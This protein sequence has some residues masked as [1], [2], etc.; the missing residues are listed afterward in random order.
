[1]S[2]FDQNT[3]SLANSDTFNNNVFFM[4]AGLVGLKVASEDR[5]REMYSLG[6]DMRLRLQEILSRYGT[7]DLDTIT[8]T[9][10]TQP[11]PR[12]YVRGL[13]SLLAVYFF[14]EYAIILKGLVS[15]IYSA[16]EYMLLQGALSRSPSRSR[17][18]MYTS[19]P[20][21]LRTLWLRTS[22]YRQREL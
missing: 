14:G 4:A 7:Y 10:T 3:G 18:I 20:R 13:G 22:G 17:P 1:M 16:I 5:I 6:D 12:M 19:L 9:L 21:Y 11:P 15:F 2:Q 8:A